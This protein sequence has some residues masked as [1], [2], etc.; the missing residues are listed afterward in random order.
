MAA[1]FAMRISGGYLKYEDVI[2]KY[3]QFK[4]GI[5]KLLIEEYNRPDLI[6][7]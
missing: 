6:V 7:K 2:A 4:E 1:Y 3:P 5:D